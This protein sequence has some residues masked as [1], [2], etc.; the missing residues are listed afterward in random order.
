MKTNLV[1]DHN[2]FYVHLQFPFSVKAK[3][4]EMLKILSPATINI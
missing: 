1:L 4:Q 2:V 3:P